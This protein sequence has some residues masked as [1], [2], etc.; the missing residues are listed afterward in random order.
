MIDDEGH[1]RLI[2]FG[3]SRLIDSE[4][5]LMTSTTSSVRWCAP[6]LLSSDDAQ[7]TKASDVYAFASTALEVSIC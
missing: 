5:G 4:P 3:L 1:A 7:V 2:D 6:E